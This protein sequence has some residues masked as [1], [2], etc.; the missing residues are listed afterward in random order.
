[1]VTRRLGQT[2][3]RATRPPGDCAAVTL[4]HHITDIVPWARRGSATACRRPGEDTCSPEKPSSTS[5][6][7]P[8]WGFR[9]SLTLGHVPCKSLPEQSAG[10]KRLD[11]QP[12]SGS[13][14]A[15]STPRNNAP[16]VHWVTPN[17]PL[18]WGQSRKGHRSTPSL[19]CKRPGGLADPL[20]QGHLWWNR[21][22][23]GTQD[24]ARW[25]VPADPRA[26]TKA[27][28]ALPRPLLA[29]SRAPRQLLAL[30]ETEPLA[31]G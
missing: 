14:G 10:D 3:G 22:R 24:T 13:R 16:S 17:W 27:P 29:P 2:G 5:D 26:G 18:E 15:Q 31:V 6:S 28:V 19:H 4:S 23:H 8:Q 9:R 20:Q 7:P 1:M 30:T 21:T 11:R 25:R 12:T